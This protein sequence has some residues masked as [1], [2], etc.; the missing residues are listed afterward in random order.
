MQMTDATF[1]VK[2]FHHLNQFVLEN[3]WTC[4]FQSYNSTICKVDYFNKIIIFWK[5]YDYSR[6]TTKHLKLFLNE[7]LSNVFEKTKDI[8]KIIKDWIFN[9][10]YSEYKVA[11]N[12]D[13]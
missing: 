2:N 5:D 12:Y 9:T 7:Y 8:E 6:T 11:L 13:L 4:I 10:P 3:D 1:K